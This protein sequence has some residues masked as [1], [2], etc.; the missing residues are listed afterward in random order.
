INLSAPELANI[1]LDGCTRI[2][3]LVLQPILDAKLTPKL[4]GIELNNCQGIKETEK[5]EVECSLLLSSEIALENL[6]EIIT[7]IGKQ[8]KEGR[9]APFKRLRSQEHKHMVINGISGTG[10]QGINLAGIEHNQKSV[11]LEAMA[12][13]KLSIL[14][15]NGYKVFT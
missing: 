4:K 11:V 5:K 13:A 8:L 15:L 9:T 1:K 10:Y 6:C 14:N 2:T 12:E 3:Y 7:Y